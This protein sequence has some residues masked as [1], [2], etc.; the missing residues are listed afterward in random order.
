MSLSIEAEKML[1]ATISNAAIK[2]S[3]KEKILWSELSTG[4][5]L[6]P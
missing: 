5:V 6:K 2:V 3:F 1:Q 4:R